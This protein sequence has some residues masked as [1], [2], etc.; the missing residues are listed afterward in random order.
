MFLAS[1]PHHCGQSPA[2]AIAADVSQNATIIVADRFEP[3]LF[4]ILNRGT[5]LRVAYFGI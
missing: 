1:D 4:R 2:G 3:W 5:R